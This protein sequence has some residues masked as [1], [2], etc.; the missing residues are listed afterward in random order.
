MFSRRR[1]LRLLGAT[2][3]LSVA[4]GGPRSAAPQDEAKGDES[5]QP[6]ESP[7]APA[8]VPIGQAPSPSQPAA[9]APSFTEVANVGPDE[10]A[11]YFAGKHPNYPG[12]SIANFLGYSPVDLLESMDT[13]VLDQVGQAH[14]QLGMDTIHAIV[15]KNVLESLLATYKTQ[16]LVLALDAGH[17]GLPSVYFEPGSNGTEWQHTRAVVTMIEQMAAD[18]RY[19][20]ITIR[21]IFND[22]I[23]D[24]FGLP[25][26]EDSKAR[27][28]LVIRN[29]RASM[30]AYEVNAWNKAHPHA[31]FAA[32]VISVHFNANSGGT[33][34]L[35]EGDDVPSDFQQ[36]S[37]AYG[38]D[39]VAR[40]RP[41]L[42]A[43]GLFTPQLDLVNGN[44][45]HDDSLMYAPPI[46]AGGS[47]VNPLTGNTM[48][49]PP[50]YAMLQ[51]SL[52]EQ[53][54]VQG[55]LNYRGL[56]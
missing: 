4:C 15:A 50:R 53:D 5:R 25:P 41:A 40:A 1:A 31:Q 36:R 54:Y 30:L 10:I 7:P 6:N 55:L 56:A 34:V 39:Y 11:L 14:G 29:A 19:E 28:S 8:I 24:D 9:T 43:T 12:A 48:H 49:G 27:A 21:R 16:S 33:L 18:R 3:A 32:H 13:A 22:A 37:M 2:L 38:S 35:H 23:G 45:L 52:L 47:R 44:G 26:P 17:G 46:R 42:N 51:G 20:S